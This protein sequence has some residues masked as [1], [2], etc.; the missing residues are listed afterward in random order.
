MKL[1]E[2]GLVILKMRY[3]KTANRNICY[4]FISKALTNVFVKSDL[5]AR[6]RIATMLET[7]QR[8]R[9]KEACAKN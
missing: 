5:R 1:P 3:Q 4:I 9:V 7:A 6:E 8:M 2:L